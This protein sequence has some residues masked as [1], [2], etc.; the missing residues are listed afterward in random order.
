MTDQTP[1][2]S[3]VPLFGKSSMEIEEEKKES[4]IFDLLNEE[5]SLEA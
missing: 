1:V 4:Q 2:L 5:L 3:K